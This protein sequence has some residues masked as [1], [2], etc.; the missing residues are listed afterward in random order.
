MANRHMKRCSMSLIIKEMET[1]H[2]VLP[3]S[4][5]NGYYQQVNRQ[6]VLV[7]MWK[8]ENHIDCWW[9]CRLLQPLWKTEWRFQKKKLELSYD[10]A[11][12]LLGIYPEKSKSLIGKYIFIPMFHCR[13]IYNNQDV[14]S[15]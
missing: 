12:A 5:Q 4:C 11:I 6:Q 1:P 3:Q 9:K 15:T 2:E 7:R 8:K 14:E 13:I 10:S